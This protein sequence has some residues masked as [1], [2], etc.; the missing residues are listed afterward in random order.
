[1]E[2]NCYYV[3]RALDGFNMP[4]IIQNLSLMDVKIVQCTMIFKKTYSQ[5]MVREIPFT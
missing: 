3:S 2:K 4:N 1:M 5:I